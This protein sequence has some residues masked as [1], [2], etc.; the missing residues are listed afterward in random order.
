[1][2]VRT[3]LSCLLTLVAT[4][5]LHMDAAGKV[6]N[7]YYPPDRTVMEF[8]L[9]SISLGIPKDSADHIKVIS[10][11]GLPRNI[12]PS[13]EN[14]CFTITMEPGINNIAIIASKEGKVIDTSVIG[15]FRR[16]EI[17][18]AYRKPPPGYTKSSFHSADNTKCGTCHTLKPS[19]DDRRPL[20]IARLKGDNEEGGQ[21]KPNSTCYSC[22]KRMVNYSYVHGPASVWSCLSCH[23]PDEKPRY[24]VKVP[25]TEACFTCHTEQR[26]K[27]YS[28]KHIHGPVNMEK[29]TICHNPH[30]T[31]YPF[32]LIK[33]SWELCV[34]CHAENSSG[35]HVLGDAF[36]SKGH[37]TR[38][39]PD[40]MRKGKELSCASCHNPHASD[41]SHLWQFDVNSLLELCTKCHGDK[42]VL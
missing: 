37:P 40:P 36:S 4:L 38:G 22:H 39:K 16:S 1:M 28:K 34:T 31:D 15:V 33:P 30:A 3:V 17:M 6:I 20:N 12:F 7:V 29:C 23:E 27:W 11:Q 26:N 13:S 19:E 24:K 21:K 18:S 42:K 32:H 35:L 25:D 2:S 9:L 41:F 14:V 10:N 8:D 5:C